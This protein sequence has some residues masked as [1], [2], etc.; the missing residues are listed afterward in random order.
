MG[1]LI[2]SILFTL[3]L[4]AV[5]YGD[6]EQRYK[7]NTILYRKTSAKNAGRTNKY[8][9]TFLASCKLATA[10][11]KYVKVSFARSRI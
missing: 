4:I 6:P 2:A 1:N 5:W 9:D 8:V 10:D 11:L 7:G 3:I